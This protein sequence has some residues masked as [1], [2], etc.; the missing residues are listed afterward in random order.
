MFDVTV[1]ILE[2]PTT[3]LNL[4]SCANSKTNAIKLTRLETLAILHLYTRA[5]LNKHVLFSKCLKSFQHKKYV[6][7][8]G[9]YD[10]L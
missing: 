5:C 1:Y 9:I 3:I 2:D 7:V 10:Q 6:T 8:E 4:F